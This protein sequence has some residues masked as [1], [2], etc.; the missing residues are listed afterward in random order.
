M[1]RTLTS[2]RGLKFCEGL[3]VHSSEFSFVFGLNS[4]YASNVRMVVI[5]EGA[6]A[7]SLK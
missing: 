2:E 7:L 5:G 3:G 1:D 6:T 4:C